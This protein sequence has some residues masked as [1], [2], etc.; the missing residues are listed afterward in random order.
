MEDYFEVQWESNLMVYIWDLWEEEHI[1]FGARKLEMKLQK[2]KW[3]K[4]IEV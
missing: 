3:W 4:F 1:L 2:E